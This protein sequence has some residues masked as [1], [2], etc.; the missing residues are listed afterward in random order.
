MSIYLFVHLFSLSH[1]YD[2]LR[3][4]ENNFK[5]ERQSDRLPDLVTFL[6]TVHIRDA[7]TSKQVDEQNQVQLAV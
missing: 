5:G 1:H 6:E 2:D 4:K 3:E 7:K